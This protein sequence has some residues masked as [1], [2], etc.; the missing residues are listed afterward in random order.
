M[1]QTPSCGFSPI[2]RGALRLTSRSG[3]RMA[4]VVS[5]TPRVALRMLQ[6]PRVAPLMASGLT[7]KA[8]AFEKKQGLFSLLSPYLG[9]KTHQESQEITARKQSNEIKKQGLEGQGSLTPRAFHLFEI[10]AFPWRLILD[11]ATE[12]LPC[13]SILGIGDTHDIPEGHSL[14]GMPEASLKAII[15]L[16]SVI[17]FE[18]RSKKAFKTSLDGTFLSD[19]LQKTF[20]TSLDK[21]MFCS[22]F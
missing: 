19:A 17:L 2:P 7:P 4:E 13:F 12:R 21:I 11:I 3:F 10:G 14:R 1:K 9:K 16:R 22:V 5:G 6:D 15:C 8:L 20:T 18:M